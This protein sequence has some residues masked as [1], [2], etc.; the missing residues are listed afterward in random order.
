MFYRPA[1]AM[2]S[3][4]QERP[5]REFKLEKNLCQTGPNVSGCSPI[6]VIEEKADLRDI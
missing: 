5:A 3:P 1:Q 4:N 2:L 6:H